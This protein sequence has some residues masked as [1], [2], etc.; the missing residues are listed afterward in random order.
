MERLFTPFFTTKAKGMG[1][2]LS[3]C[4]KF[5]ESHGGSIEVESEVGKG[6]VFTVKLL[7]HQEGGGE[8]T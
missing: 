5:V 7:I 4:K 3:I 1:I 6:T 8:K 2:G